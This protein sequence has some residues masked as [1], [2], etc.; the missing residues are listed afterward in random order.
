MPKAVTHEARLQDCEDAIER[1]IDE[2]SGLGAKLGPVLIQTPPS[3]RFDGNL[4]QFLNLWRSRFM[5]ETVWEPRH[6]TWFTPEAEAI[7]SEYQVARAAADPA[8]VPEAARPGGW[9]DLAYIR[10]HGSPQ[11]YASA[12]GPERVAELAAPILSQANAWCIFD[13]TQFGAATR[14]AL[15]LHD[16]VAAA[17]L[18]ES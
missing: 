13:N 14:D 3:L 12:Y 2:I 15:I 6:R 11:V 5:G 9:R 16:Q 1:F 8:L 10:L 7:L 18:G 17:T 4:P